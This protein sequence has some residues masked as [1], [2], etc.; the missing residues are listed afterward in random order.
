M[1]TSS[2]PYPYL[3]PGRTIEYVQEN[4]R[5][6][7][8]AAELWR[9]HDTYCKQG[10]TAVVVKDGQIISEGKNGGKNPPAVCQRKLLGC[11]T[12]EG[13]ELC[14]GCDPK[15][16]AEPSALNKLTTGTA[17]GADLYLYGHWWCCEPCWNSMIA[18][19][20]EHVFLVE[21]A[22]EKFFDAPIN[23]GGPQW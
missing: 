20:I 19:G 8:R 9:T 22:T 6:M 2:L 16:H 13:Y 4:N 5:F 21:Q 12:G 14:P 17:Q 11:K 23:P 1:Y 10:T 7:A 18:S 15:N 3:P